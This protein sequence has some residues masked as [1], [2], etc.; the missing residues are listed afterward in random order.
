MTTMEQNAGAFTPS[1]GTALWPIALHPGAGSTAARI[2]E[3]LEN[4]GFGQYFTDHMVR[5]TWT[6]DLGWHGAELT[7]YGPLSLDPATNFLH[8]GQAIFEGLKAYRHA[9]GSIQTFRVL[10]NAERFAR[11][12]RRLAM[13]EV[14][15]ELFIGAIEALVRQDR[16]WVPSG[17]ERSL[18][19]RPFLLGTQ[20]RSALTSAAIDPMKSSSEI[21]AIARRRAELLKRVAFLSGR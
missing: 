18:Y 4:P 5:A 2:D 9:D 1:E 15:V 12:A 8:Y 10:Q 13:A 11:S 17:A 16:A 20:S 6:H 3:V 14:P 7:P 21:S 19:L